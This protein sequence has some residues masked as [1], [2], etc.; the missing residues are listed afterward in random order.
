MVKFHQS[1][2][3][4]QQGVATEMLKMARVPKEYSNTLYCNVTTDNISY[5]QQKSWGLKCITANKKI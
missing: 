1:E 4:R 3:F 5:E 2:D